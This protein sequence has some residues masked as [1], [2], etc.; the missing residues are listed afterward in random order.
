M[1]KP[2][3]EFERMIE[4]SVAR[5][6]QAIRGPDSHEHSFILVDDDRMLA[7]GMQAEAGVLTMR[8]ICLRADLQGVA[9][10]PETKAAIYALAWNDEHPKSR[11]TAVPWRAALAGRIRVLKA[12]LLELD[13]FEAES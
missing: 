9:F 13:G 8:M 6:E 1:S 7:L 4:E 11:V 3:S 5:F 12:M 2:M 10:L